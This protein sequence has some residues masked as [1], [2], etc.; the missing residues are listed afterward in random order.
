MAVADSRQTGATSPC[1]PSPETGRVDARRSRPGEPSE[2]DVRPKTAENIMSMNQNGFNNEH[3]ISQFDGMGDGPTTVFLACGDLR[4]WE[5]RILMRLHVDQPHRFPVHIEHGFAH[6]VIGDEVA[7]G[8]VVLD[9][10]DDEGTRTVVVYMGRRVPPWVVSPTPQ[11]HGW[12]YCTSLPDRTNL[13]MVEVDMLL[14]DFND[15]HVRGWTKT[16][17]FPTFTPRPMQ[18]VGVRLGDGEGPTVPVRVLEVGGDLIVDGDPTPFVIASST[19]PASPELLE[20]F[21]WAEEGW[22]HGK[23]A[24][25]RGLHEMSEVVEA[26]VGVVLGH[27]LVTEV[28]LHQPGQLADHVLP[29]LPR[30][31]RTAIE[32]A[33]N[34]GRDGRTPNTPT[35]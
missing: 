20:Q 21:K 17:W 31:V 27:A 4:G 9:E 29:L 2:K 30:D 10:T 32:F 13:Y 19:Q 8:P 28:T 26:H 22:V 12:E 25:W 18:R 23:R 14:L 5:T 7:Y 35:R 33:T 24:A 6:V 3:H 1:S 11:Q 16:V 34:D 15:L